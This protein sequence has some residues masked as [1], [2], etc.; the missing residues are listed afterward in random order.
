MSVYGLFKTEN[1]TTFY[2][3]LLFSSLLLLIYI[4]VQVSRC[5]VE[6]NSNFEAASVAKDLVL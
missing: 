1:P 3:F 4:I 5:N 6:N 2:T